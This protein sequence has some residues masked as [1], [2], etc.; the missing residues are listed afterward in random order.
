[1]LK[2]TNKLYCSRIMKSSE[3]FKRLILLFRAVVLLFCF[4]LI[5]LVFTFLVI[6]YPDILF[7]SSSKEGQKDKSER[8]TTVWRA[9]DL[10]T[11][12]DTE[13]GK[14]IRYGQEL[15]VHTSSFIGPIGTIS[16]KGNGMN[17]QNCHLNAGTKPFGNN[18]GSVAS[19]YP[20]FR[21]RSGIVESIERRVNDCIIRS[22][23]GEALDSLSTEMRAIVSYIKWVGKEVKHGEL[24]EGSGLL[25]MQWL[26]RAADRKAGRKLYLQKC[27][28]CHGNKGEGQRLTEKGNFLYPPLSGEQTFTTSAGLYRLSSF[29]KYIYTNM[30]YGATYESPMLSE[31]EAWDIAA[32]VLSLPRP[33]RSFDGDWPKIETKPLDH[34]FGPF[35]D[36]FS[37]E[38][39]K[40][41][42]FEPIEKFYKE[43]KK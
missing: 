30:P 32:Y 17:C 31:E 36:T 7:H 8:S 16:A 1:L 42:P 39:H 5:F 23:N 22:L 24:A 11:I 34:P 12:P 37:E 38:Q 21:N 35:A 19:T 27:Q 20:K 40:Y 14:L 41:G 13:E 6:R 26:N 33:E 10:S 25:T 2:Q 18:F 29:T 3:G 28:V 4:Y 43:A 15:I 9:P